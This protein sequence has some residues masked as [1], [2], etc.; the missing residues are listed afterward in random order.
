MHLRGTGCSWVP[1]ESGD[2]DQ[3]GRAGIGRF[4]SERELL[5]GY[6][7][8]IY[9]TNK[10]TVFF[11]FFGLGLRISHPSHAQET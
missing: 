5:T 2:L 1:D 3:A 11:N 6:S 9:A 10:Q 4:F 7:L 8:T